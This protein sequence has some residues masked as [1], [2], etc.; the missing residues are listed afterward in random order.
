M[1]PSD[2]CS[3]IDFS[4]CSADHYALSS[5]QD[6]DDLLDSDHFPMSTS[7]DIG[8]PFHAGVTYFRWNRICHDFNAALPDYSNFN[9]NSFVSMAHSIMKNHKFFRGSYSRDFRIGG[10]LGV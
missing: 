3:L 10:L 5:F 2:V 1:A 9:Y 6:L 7:V 4:L 8:S